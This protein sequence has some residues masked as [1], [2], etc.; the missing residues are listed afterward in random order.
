[1]VMR[2]SE[3]GR[4]QGDKERGRQGENRDGSAASVSPCLLVSPSPC[5]LP[6][7]CIAFWALAG[8]AFADDRAPHTEVQWKYVAESAEPGV[9]RPVMQKVTLL[10]ELP[11]N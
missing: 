9:D 7:V 4:R 10:D 8:A 5:L 11:D 2:F 6:S 3:I 1:M